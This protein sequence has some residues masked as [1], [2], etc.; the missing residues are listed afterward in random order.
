MLPTHEATR[1][2]LA[3]IHSLWVFTS[4]ALIGA[5]FLLIK[6]PEVIN[7]R[8]ETH[9][10]TVGWDRIW[11]SVYLVSYICL[12]ILV[13]AE[14][15]IKHRSTISPDLWPLG[16]FFTALGYIFVVWA[17]SNNEFF[18]MTVRIQKERGHRLIDTGAYSIVRHPGYTGMLIMFVGQIFL[19]GSIWAAWMI[20]AMSV[21]LVVRTWLE[22]LT[23]Q[24][25][26]Q[27]Y[28]S[29]TERVRYRLI[30]GIW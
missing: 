11:V 13:G 25:D 18:E 4:L 2:W 26:L 19:Y 23:L 1:D 12:W 21:L 20:V 7:A 3:L 10:G 17:M 6:N 8:S 28:L 22:D 30:P 5:V 24:R 16:F 27:G 14:Y 15:A 9:E 29:Y